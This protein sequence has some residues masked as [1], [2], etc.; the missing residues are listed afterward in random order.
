MA[1]KRKHVGSVDQDQNA[2]KK[3]MR[4][5]LSQKKE[6]LGMLDKGVHGNVIAVRYGVSETTI[7]NV[8][9]S[10]EKILKQLADGDDPVLFVCFSL[11]I[12]EYIFLVCFN[13]SS[14]RV[15]IG[16]MPAMEKALLVW[17]QLQRANNVEISGPL[18]MEK[19]T[20][21]SNQLVSKNLVGDSEKEILKSFKA[22]SG[23][24]QKFC[25]RHK[26]SAFVES[27]EANSV[28]AEAILKGRSEA[29]AKIAEGKYHIDDIYNADETGLFYRMPPNRTLAQQSENVKGVKRSKSRVTALVCCN[30]SGTDKRKMLLIGKS[31]NPHCFK[32]VNMN[33]VNCRYNSTDKAW[34]SVR[35]FNDFLKELND[36]MAKQKRRII[37]FIDQAPVH[38]V[39]AEYEHV[40]V[41]KL[42]ANT[43]S[44]IQ[45]VMRELFGHLK[46]ITVSGS[47]GIC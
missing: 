21:I 5:Q 22:S 11:S 13:Q 33:N 36:D 39:T 12:M 34:M 15:R 40:K 24:L 17:F 20:E 14:K 6:I 31:K 18:L 9:S 7:S 8:K 19:A 1:E 16:R 3:A 26:I 27:G 35:I 47:S 28:K 4:L 37:L 10:R 32:N 46:H 45:H 38:K 42:E 29:I 41:E 2:K 23:F 25:Q 30:A 44:V 43:T